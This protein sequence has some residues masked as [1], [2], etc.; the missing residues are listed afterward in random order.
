MPFIILARIT[1]EK[2]SIG[3]T[4]KSVVLS[5]ENRNKIDIMIERKRFIEHRKLH[6]SKRINN[7]TRFLNGLSPNPW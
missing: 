5:F 2:N 4:N 3:V 6:K 7:Q 1:T